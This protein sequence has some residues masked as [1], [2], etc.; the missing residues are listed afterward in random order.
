MPFMIGLTGGIAS[1]KTTAARFFAQL[2][3]EI[4]DTDAIAHELTQADGVAVDTI[5]QVFGDRFIAEDGALK[6]SEMRALI[7]SDSEARKKLET[8]LHPLIRCE[9]ARRAGAIAAPYGM[10]VVPLLLETKGY[11]G[12]RELIRRV[13]V[14]DCDEQNQIAHAIVRTGMDERMVRAI[15]DTQLSRQERLRQADDIIVNDGDME[16]L[17]RQVRC[18]HEKYLGLARQD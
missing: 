15:M 4:I 13:L 14:V 16:G 1:G 9:V 3:A 5:R 17:E 8:I 6:R 2:G 10:V 7:F 12:Y 18:L 11:P